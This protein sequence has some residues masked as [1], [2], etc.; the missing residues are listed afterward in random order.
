MHNRGRSRE[1]YAEASYKDVVAEVKAELMQAVDRATNAGV[2]RE[3]IILDPGFG[4]AKRA[5]HSIE[6]LTKLDQLATLGFPILS[7]P[8]R[9]SFLKTALGDRTPAQREWGTA[10]AVTV[11]VLRGAQLVR[12]HSVRDMVDVVRVADLL[13]GARMAV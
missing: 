6:L 8:S 1:M 5:E 2:Q 13:R 10:A 4:F 9:K 7:G 3:T 11:S 12:V